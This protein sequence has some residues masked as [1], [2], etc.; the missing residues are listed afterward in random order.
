MG[1]GASRHEYLRQRMRTIP[2][3]LDQNEAARLT[4]PS[5]AKSSRT[6]RKNKGHEASSE[7][8][9]EVFVSRIHSAPPT[10]NSHNTITRTVDDPPPAE[11]PSSV[12]RAAFTT[13]TEV[14]LSQTQFPERLR[15]S[16]SR[17]KK[18]Q[19]SSSAP[20]L[21][22]SMRSTHASNSSSHSNFDGNSF[23]QPDASGVLMLDMDAGLS[24]TD[25][26]ATRTANSEANVLDFTIARPSTSSRPRTSVRP[27]T[28][29]PLTAALAHAHSNQSNLFANPQ[30]PGS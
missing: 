3:D 7:V 29:R 14:G 27:S 13:D 20:P 1:A 19:D 5:S 24:A 28:A 9:H 8:D 22:P 17:T 18:S 25:R 21:A 12:N 16:I 10:A 30:L 15:T 2:L 6:S 4:S 11:L 23:Q 26:F